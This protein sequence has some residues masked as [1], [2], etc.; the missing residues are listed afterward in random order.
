MPPRRRSSP[1]LNCKL[2]PAPQATHARAHNYLLLF[3]GGSREMKTTQDDTD[4]N[5]QQFRDEEPW[6]LS[7]NAAGGATPP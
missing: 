7:T 2:E 1:P 4:V 6:A 5:T 3:P